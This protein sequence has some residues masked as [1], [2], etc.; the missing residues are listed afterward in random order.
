MKI[1]IISD[2]HYEF[3]ECELH[4]SE[5]MDVLV[6]AGDVATKPSIVAL[7]LA[8][9]QKMVQVP[10]VFVL[11]NHEYYG[12]TLPGS[13]FEYASKLH[14]LPNIHMLDRKEWVYG[15]VRFLGATLW[16]DLSNPM[17]AMNARAG[18]SDYH[19]INNAEGYLLTPEDTTNEWHKA[20]KYLTEQLHNHTFD[21]KTVVVTHH[22]PS[23][24]TTPDQFRGNRLQPAFSSRMDDLIRE[25]EPDLWVYGHDHHTAEHRIGNTRLVSCQAGYPYERRE[26]VKIQVV[27]I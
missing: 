22:A 26:P 15:D 27:E 13:T 11:G 3:G 20:N 8:V 4:W 7:N 23:R 19:T 16:S 25:T 1:G 2:I 10:V 6:V 12:G 18:I 14:N 5:P 24:V 17:D 9:I 21:G